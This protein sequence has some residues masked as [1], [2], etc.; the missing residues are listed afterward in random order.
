M[1]FFNRVLAE[2]PD[3]HAPSIQ[4]R[5]TVTQN[6]PCYCPEIRAAKV[7]QR[8]LE[9][10]FDFEPPDVK[11]AA[12][13]FRE[14]VKQKYY[15]Q[16]ISSTTHQKDLCKVFDQL[17]HKFSSEVHLPAKK[18]PAEAFVSTSVIKSPKSRIHSHQHRRYVTSKVGMP[19]AWYHFPTSLSIP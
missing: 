18:E 10:M 11:E 17:L 9:D 12:K 13:S 1:S 3:K 14:Q 2:L 16:K 8:K 15:L 6:S 5:I 7:E 4:A 19:M